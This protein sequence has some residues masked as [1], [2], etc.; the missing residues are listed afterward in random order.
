MTPPR[1]RM[2][3]LLFLLTVAGCAALEPQSGKPP[4]AVGEPADMILVTGKIVTVD[5]RFTIT[6]A[7]AIRNRPIVAVGSNSE[8]RGH[9]GSNTR[10]IDAG[11]RTVI[12]GLIDGHS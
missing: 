6:Q 9:S 2:F 8:I 5:D 1:Q 11:G 10:V 4:V 3:A 12:P 7:L